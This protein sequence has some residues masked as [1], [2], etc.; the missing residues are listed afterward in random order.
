MPNSA[1]GMRSRG[2]V[3]IANSAIGMGF[4]FKSN[5]AIGMSSRGFVLACPIVL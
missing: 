3:C 1:I 2:F 5:S 4:D